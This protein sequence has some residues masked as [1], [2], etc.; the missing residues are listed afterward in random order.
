MSCGKCGAPTHDGDQFCRN[1]HSTIAPPSAD[2]K[3]PV[4]PSLHWAIVFVLGCV[5]LG[6][7]TWAWSLRQAAFVKK[8]APS[9]RA[10]EM[11]GLVLALHILQVGFW[12]AFAL[13]TAQ[14]AA[15]VNQQLSSGSSYQATVTNSYAASPRTESPDAAR[16]FLDFLEL[17]SLVLGLIA[18]FSMR[19]SIEDYYNTVEPIGLHLSGVMILFFNVTYLQYHLSRIAAWRRTGWRD[20]VP[21]GVSSGNCR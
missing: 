2:S 10:I 11:L 20:Q 13:A 19:K 3:G 1:C 6:I 21:V 18:L 9:S 17:A 12:I 16:L 4:P 5:T 7:F 8:L 14:N 15:A